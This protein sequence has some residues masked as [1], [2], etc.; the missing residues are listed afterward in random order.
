MKK[1]LQH[2]DRDTIKAL[3]KALHRETGTA[4]DHYLSYD[5]KVALVAQVALRVIRANLRGVPPK[6]VDE[7]YGALLVEAGLE[8]GPQD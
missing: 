6:A 5:L 3:V 7:L 2:W 1:P 4:W 8:D